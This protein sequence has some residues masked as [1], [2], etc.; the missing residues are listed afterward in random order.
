MIQSGQIKRG[1]GSVR[2]NVI[3]L[4]TGIY[5]YSVDT[6]VTNN[7]DAVRRRTMERGVIGRGKVWIESSK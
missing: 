1:F 5:G 3:V 2:C 6:T 4:K 7:V